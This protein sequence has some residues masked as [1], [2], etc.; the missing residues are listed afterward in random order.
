MTCVSQ[1]IQRERD[2]DRERREQMNES[3][4]KIEAMGI[5]NLVLEITYHH[6]YL[7]LL[8]MQTKPSI[9]WKGKHKD[10]TT[11]RLGSLGTI[12]ET[13]YYMWDRRREIIL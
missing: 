12:L 4:P 3:V 9:S 11:R 2:R 7:I 8:V 5:Y 6:V 10:V 13:G 1:I